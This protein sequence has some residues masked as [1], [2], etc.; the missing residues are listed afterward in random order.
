MASRV[1]GRLWDDDPRVAVLRVHEKL[2][3]SPDTLQEGESELVVERL[4]AALKET[5]WRAN[6][7]INGAHVAHRFP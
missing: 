7:E 5:F 4:V 2:F 6:G 3:V 1:S